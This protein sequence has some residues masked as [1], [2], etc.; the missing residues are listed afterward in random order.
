MQ[1]SI[2]IAMLG[3]FD[4]R[5]SQHQTEA[6]LNHAAE[7][8]ALP[9]KTTWLATSALNAKTVAAQLQPFHGVWA[10]PGD[11]GH[12]Q[13]VHAAIGLCREQKIPFIGT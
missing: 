6:A 2:N 12:P 1:P 4:H 5:P 3:D 10:G 11:Y 13:G 9:V 8:K 7:E